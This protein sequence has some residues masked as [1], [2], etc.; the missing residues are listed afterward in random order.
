MSK[1]IGDGVVVFASMF[2]VARLL[3]IEFF[4]INT[5]IFLVLEGMLL[6]IMLTSFMSWTLR[7]TKSVIS[8]ERHAGFYT[9]SFGHDNDDPENEVW[10][11]GET[12]R[13]AVAQLLIDHPECFGIE[14]K[15]SE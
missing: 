5:L 11:A 9:A 13:D 4:G 15:I 3:V 6:A 14:V 12:E 2:L 8:V 7:K 10:S 1:F